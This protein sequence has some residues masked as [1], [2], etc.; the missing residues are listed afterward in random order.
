MGYNAR[1]SFDTKFSIGL[2]VALRDWND[3]LYDMWHAYKAVGDIESP[4]A[5]AGLEGSARKIRS[6]RNDLRMQVVTGDLFVQM[7][8]IHG[9]EHKEALAGDMPAEIMRQY[10]TLC[11]QYYFWTN[12]DDDRRVVI[13]EMLDEYQSA[14]DAVLGEEEPTDDA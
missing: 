6:I 7:M 11:V 13:D 9:E 8:R 4:L 5:K 12:D 2:A 3:K 14:I 1:R 10:S